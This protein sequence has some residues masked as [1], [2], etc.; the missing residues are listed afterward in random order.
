[1][2]A[3]IAAATPLLANVGLR[4]FIWSSFSCK[5]PGTCNQLSIKLPCSLHCRRGWCGVA[6]A[7]LWQWHVI[8]V[9]CRPNAVHCVTE[10]LKRAR[11]HRPDSLVCPSLASCVGSW[12]GW[13]VAIDRLITQNP[14]DSVAAMC[15]S[16]RGSSL[17][18]SAQPVPGRAHVCARGTP[19]L[20][21]RLLILLDFACRMS[22]QDGPHNS[23]C[24]LSYHL[25]VPYFHMFRAVECAHV[26]WLASCL[27]G[28]N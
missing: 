21:I 10:L 15:L 14:T 1:M 20:W 23:S 4:F 13:A 18:L 19:L 9:S 24:L 28:E 27:S 5:C 2:H 3:R 22:F 11:R 12:L 6:R 7:L 8:R 25:S 16:H 26:R 17:F